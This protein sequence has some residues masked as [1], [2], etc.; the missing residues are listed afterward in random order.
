MLRLFGLCCNHGQVEANVSPREQVFE[1]G[2]LPPDAPLQMSSMFVTTTEL[3]IR[4]SK[5]TPSWSCPRRQMFYN[6]HKVVPCQTLERAMLHA[7]AELCGGG[8]QKTR[9]A[10]V[11]GRGE[12]PGKRRDASSRTWA[13]PGPRS[14]HAHTRMGLVH[15]RH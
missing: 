12:N 14:S 3:A 2:A 13:S 11:R 7:P 6:R 10:D 15:S 1:L 4:S 5:R 9:C 8:R